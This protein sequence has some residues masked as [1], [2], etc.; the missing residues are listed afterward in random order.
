MVV[1]KNPMIFIKC[2]ILF[3][4]FSILVLVK[5]LLTNRSKCNNTDIVKIQPNNL[6]W[7]IL[8]LKKHKG[9]NS[10]KQTELSNVF[11]IL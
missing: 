8:N 5:T 3:K 9:Q 7:I 6:K 2:F 4:K 1:C 11:V 10:V